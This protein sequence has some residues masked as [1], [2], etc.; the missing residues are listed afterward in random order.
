MVPAFNVKT[1][2]EKIIPII[3]AFK[4]TRRILSTSMLVRK[5]IG[6]CCPH[7]LDIVVVVAVVVY[8]LFLGKNA[9]GGLFRDHAPA[10]FQM[11]L[12]LE[13][14]VVEMVV[15]LLVGGVLE[16]DLVVVV[17]TNYYYYLSSTNT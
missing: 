12:L 9:L 7:I 13:G 3:V 8:V 17:V 14:A 11:D 4:P 2:R 10:L 15:V 5:H 1:A 6:Y 16:E